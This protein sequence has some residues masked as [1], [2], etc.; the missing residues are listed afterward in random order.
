MANTGSRFSG[1]RVR[2]NGVLRVRG[3]E[4]DAKRERRDF[5]W[6]GPAEPVWFTGPVWF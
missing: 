1:L 2:G 6:A 3:E 4:E 5:K